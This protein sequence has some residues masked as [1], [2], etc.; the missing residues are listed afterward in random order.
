[1]SFAKDFCAKMLA[2]AVMAIL[3]LPLHRKDLRLL[4]ESDI[5]GFIPK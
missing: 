4:K 5:E 2:R 1:M 3:W